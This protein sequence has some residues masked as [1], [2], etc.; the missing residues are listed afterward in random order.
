MTGRLR[1]RA[2]RTRWVRL[3]C[4]ISPA[5]AAT[6]ALACS[7]GS[8][9]RP[10]PP[11]ASLSVASAMRAGGDEGFERALAPRPFHFPAD[12]GP[13][14]GFRTEW[15][16]FTGNLAAPD[17]RR[18]G[19]Q[20]TVFR[21]A[22]APPADVRERASAWATRQAWLAHFALTDVEG[23]RFHS[24]AR[25]ARG[26]LGLAGARASPFRVWVEDWGMRA[27]GE[28]AATRPGP[29]LEPETEPGPADLGPLRLHAA[30]GGDAVDLRLESLGPPVLQGDHGLSH[31]G[32]G[33]G[34]AS[35]YYSVPRLA[36]RGSVT[37]DGREYPVTG[38][39]WLDREWSTS[40]L[41]QGEVGWD[42]FALQLSDGSDLMLYRLRR[43]DGSID[44]ASSGTLVEPRA[45]TR[46]LAAS[47][48]SIAVQDHWRSPRSGALYP[49]R[50]RVVVPAAGLDLEIEP[51]LADQE[52]DVGLRYWEGAV[53]ITGSRRGRPV[54]GHGYVELTG[55]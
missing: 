55:Y 1:S 2:G 52:L 16:Y 27:E 25:L 51:L 17:G 11:R 46:H 40:A 38:L 49:A 35:Y 23:A 33:P 21:Q 9:A 6:C 31:K 43:E 42:W 48:V 44:P 22:L 29:E 14:P 47:D 45:G 53:A 3:A 28:N 39:S 24:A 7:P 20:L 36:T 4:L 54:T 50:W 26:A 18:F 5:V 15:W 41:A 13:H 12:H 30:D 10:E 37:A 8:Q 34:N 19:Y 32:G